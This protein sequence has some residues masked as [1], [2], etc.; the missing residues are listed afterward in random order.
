MSDVWVLEGIHYDSGETMNTI[1]QLRIAL[2]IANERELKAS[3]SLAI[4][5]RR[6]VKEAKKSFRRNA[7]ES[8]SDSMLNMPR[9]ARHQTLP[10]FPSEKEKVLFAAHMKRRE[11]GWIRG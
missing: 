11:S 2:G 3:R 10:R 1:E 4:P 7:R 6:R 8:Q 5:T 9:P